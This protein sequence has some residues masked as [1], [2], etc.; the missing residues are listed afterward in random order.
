MLDLKHLTQFFHNFAES[1]IRGIPE[2]AASYCV[3]PNI[4]R[5]NS[6]RVLNTEDELTQFFMSF[7]RKLSGLCIE[8]CEPI[9]HQTLRLSDALI[10]TTMRWQLPNHNNELIGAG[11]P[12]IPYKKWMMLN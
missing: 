6:K 1:I 4:I 7:E 5:D 12:P 10:F 9:I 11:R 3:I 2:V 8:Q